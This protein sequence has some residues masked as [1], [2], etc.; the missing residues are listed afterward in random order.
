MSAPG[1]TVDGVTFASLETAWEVAL[2]TS[3]TV[4]YPRFGPLPAVVAVHG[5][6]G[7]WDTAGK[8]RTL[9]LSNGSVIE[10]ITDVT[11]PFFFGYDLS[12]FTGFFGS[13]VAGAR[14]EWTF[15]PE[16]GG[17]R[18]QWTYAFHPKPG[19]G[20]V[21]SAVVALFWRRYMQRVLPAILT[22][23]DARAS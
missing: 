8:S 6:D 4:F 14:A 16:A 15:T 10:T 1:A 7:A 13:V 12:D 20:L 9:E 22:A 2:L 17:T 11:F 19:G 21:V 18:I 5:Q 23:A 3:P